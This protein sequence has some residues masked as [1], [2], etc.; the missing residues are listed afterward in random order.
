MMFTF[1]KPKKVSVVCSISVLVRKFDVSCDS[2][3][4]WCLS[5]SIIILCQW[6]Q[7]AFFFYEDSPVVDIGNGVQDSHLGIFDYS[8]VH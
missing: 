2:L 3:T 6:L 1:R 4:F 5:H 7:M 8:S